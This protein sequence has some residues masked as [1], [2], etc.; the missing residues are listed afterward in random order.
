MFESHVVIPNVVEVQDSVAMPEVQI[1]TDEENADSVY[2]YNV[3][4]S[5]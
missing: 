5:E 1:E 2:D 3:N 4:E